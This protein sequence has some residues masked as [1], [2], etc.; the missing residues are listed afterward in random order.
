LE[1][2][3]ILVVSAFYSMSV[4]LFCAEMVSAYRRRD[5]TLLQKAFL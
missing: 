2:I 3:V 1:A 4:L 5:V